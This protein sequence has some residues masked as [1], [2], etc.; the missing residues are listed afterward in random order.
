MK[1]L[2]ATALVLVLGVASASA[3]VEQGDKEVQ[4]AGSLYSA[5][6]FTVINLM[7]VY[8]YYIRPNIEIGAGPSITRFD[9]AGYSST[10][11]GATFFG[12][13]YFTSKTNLVP[14]LS[15]QWYQFDLA[16]EDPLS[17]SDV[18]YIQVGGGAKYFVN[19]YIA[20]DGSANLG[21]GLGGGT[22]FLMQVGLSA[23]F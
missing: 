16:P 1:Y 11:V 5:E 18:A 13:Y 10:T 6:G 15:G 2:L 12:R 23:F 7:S 8:G 4:F 3:Q 22:A 14:Y 9:F 17:F 19:E 20:W 21:F